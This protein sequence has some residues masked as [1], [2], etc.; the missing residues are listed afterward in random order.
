VVEVGKIE[1]RVKSYGSICATECAS[2]RGAIGD[3]EQGK[4][5]WSG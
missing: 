1:N 4:H 5:E 2:C 3:K